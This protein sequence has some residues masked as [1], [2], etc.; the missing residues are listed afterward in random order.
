MMAQHA[1]L[2]TY[3]FAI[4]MKKDY[5]AYPSHL[6]WKQTTSGVAHMYRC[7]VNDDVISC[8]WQR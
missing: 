1:S 4:Q 2:N 5:L 8:K 3:F 6:K 7:V